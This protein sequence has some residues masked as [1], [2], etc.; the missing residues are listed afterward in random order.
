MGL[1]DGGRR[2][3]DVGVVLAQDQLQ[4][5]ERHPGH[6]GLLRPRH[7]PRPHGHRPHVLQVGGRVRRRGVRDPR[8]AVA[9]QRRRHASEVRPGRRRHLLEQAVLAD[10]H[11]VGEAGLE[12]GHSQGLGVERPRQPRAV[13]HPH[14]AVLHRCVQSRPVERAGTPAVVGDAPQPLARTQAPACC[15]QHAGQAG[16]VHHV[17]RPA[18]HRRPPGRLGEQVQVV[19]VQAGKQRAATGVDIDLSGR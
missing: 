12:P 4:R 2:V 3:L 13:L 10:Q 7:G 9:A 16:L 1:L 15:S 6:L 18:G 19:V 17:G 14:R 11:T 5:P 8:D